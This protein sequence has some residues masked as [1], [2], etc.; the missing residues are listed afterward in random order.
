MK[1]IRRSSTSGYILAESVLLLLFSLVLSG[2]VF[3]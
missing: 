2:G 3:P 1:I